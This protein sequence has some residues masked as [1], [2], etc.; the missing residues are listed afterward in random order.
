MKNI[1]IYLLLLLHTSIHAQTEN[2]ATEFFSVGGGINTSFITGASSEL[3]ITYLKNYQKELN[4]LNYNTTINTLPKI[5][6]S[7]G[8]NYGI[9]FND[10]LMCY[11][12]FSY[13]PRGFTQNFNTSLNGTLIQKN[14][15]TLTT[16]YWDF[17]FGLRH[18]S[19]NGI[20]ADL[21]V[22]IW[23]NILDKVEIETTDYTNGNEVTT[24]TNVLMQD[25]YGA[26]RNIFPLA[27]FVNVGYQSKWWL[28]LLETNY[29]GNI[30]LNSDI[31][32]SYFTIGLKSQFVISLQE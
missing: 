23:Y 12:G 27:A 29:S 15:F 28:V 17:H 9:P 18:R 14:K 6:Y 20:I 30:F 1:R 31:D 8:A 25:Y 19:K 21:G 3:Q 13:S 2:T 24:K 26:L 11:T 10:K 16:N 4:T 22:M 32:L 5:S 7:F